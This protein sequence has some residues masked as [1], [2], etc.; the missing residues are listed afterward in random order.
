MADSQSLFDTL[1]GSFTP[2][3]GVNR[4]GLNA[5]VAS[6]QSANGLRTAQ[7]DAAIGNAQKLQDETNARHA[8]ESN[9]SGV[10]DDAGNPLHTPS[11]AKLIASELIAAGGQ[12]AEGIMKA[13]GEALKNR[14][15]KTLG[16]ASQLNTPAQTAASQVTTGK[17]A[18]PVNL[19]NNYTAPAGVVV[20]PG[21][22]VQ[23][24]AQ[25]AQTRAMTGLD[26]AR[27]EDEHAK[28]THAA[29]AANGSLDPQTLSDAA[30]VVMADPQ[31]MSQYAGFGATGQANKDGINNAISRTLNAS[32]MTANDMIRQR[33]LAKASVGAAGAAAKQAEVLDAFTPLVKS[34]GERIMQLL[35]TVGDDGGDMPMLAGLERAGGRALGSDDLAELHSVMGTYQNEVARLLASSPTMTGVISDKARGDVQAMAPENMTTNQA[36]RVINRINTEISLR[37]QGIQTSLDNSTGAQL[38][39]TSLGAGGVGGGPPSPGA[40]AGGVMSLDDYLTRNGH[41][42]KK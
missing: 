24:V 29:S 14:A 4:P 26:V 42:A 41:P 35:N 8:L 1:A 13:Y 17:L 16:D 40:P 38:P 27:A 18:E 10:V 36:K 3:G 25:T 30:L 28:A 9:L 37:R 7:T 19:P 12:G 33:A 15:T 6:N 22:S 20:N 21:Q 32:G 31:K 11:E 39:V 34:N 2:G 5:F 23:G